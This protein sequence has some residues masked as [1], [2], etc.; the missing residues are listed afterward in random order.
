MLLGEVARRLAGQRMGL[1]VTDAAT[2]WIAEDGF[3]REFGARPLRR[4]IQRSVENELSR[5][6]LA[7]ELREGQRA[8]IDRAGDELVVE[9]E[10]DDTP[11]PPDWED[12]HDG[13]TAVT[14]R[15]PSDPRHAP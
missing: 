12:A 11:V 8:L 4:T 7:G 2:A 9:V 6:V 14:P 5:R 15:G 3:D 10:S 1:H 13:S